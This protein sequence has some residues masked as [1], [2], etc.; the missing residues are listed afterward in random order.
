MAGGNSTFRDSLLPAVDVLR[1]I[2]AALGLRLFTVAVL[3]RTWSGSRVGVGSATDALTGVKVDLGIYPT[4]VRV[5][6]VKDIVASGGIYTDQDVEVGPITPPFSGSSQDG[7]AI[8]VFDPV[9]GQAPGE[10][11]FRITGPGYPTAGAW[12][13]KISQRVDKSFRYTFI[14]RKTAEVP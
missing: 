11:F 10:V 12:F 4:K 5:L 3:Y 13:R 7:D 1:G 14:V 2:P 6:T 8:T 9:P